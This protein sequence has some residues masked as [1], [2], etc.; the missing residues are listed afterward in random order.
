[1]RRFL[2]KI[3]T[4]KETCQILWNTFS[5]RK[6]IFDDWNF[7]LTFHSAYHQKIHFITIHN[8]HKTVGLLP[9]AWDAEEKRFEWFGTEWQENNRFFYTDTD[10]F[11]YLFTLI[12]RPVLLN[13]VIPDSI[14]EP[15][16]KTKFLPDEYQYVLD[17]RRVNSYD[18]L[19]AAFGK[20][21]R[22]NLR[23]DTQRILNLNPLIDWID[24]PVEQIKL[25]DEVKKL[26]IRR[27]GSEENESASTFRKPRYMQSFKNIINNQGTYLIKFLRVKIRGEIAAVDII[28]LY[29]DTYYLF[30]GGCNSERFPGIGSFMYAMEFQDAIKSKMKWVNALQE[31]HNWKHRYFTER[32]L[33]KL[34]RK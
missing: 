24:R 31:D 22:Y 14:P 18:Q 19:L 10:T 11:S 9:L 17:L 32:S 21:Y 25:L 15:T 7:R 1:M 26:S 33:V 34:V 4:D 2:S 8:N 12:P 3:H 16:Y 13:A 28:G 20:K 29:K 30:I 6:S 27:F 23:R 5:K